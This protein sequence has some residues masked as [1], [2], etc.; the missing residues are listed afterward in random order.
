M[1]AADGL[2]GVMAK[3]HTP[4]P[5]T[6]GRSCD[7]TPA[8]IVPVPAGEGTG[9][10]VAHINRIPRMG[11]VRGDAD[12]NA[13]LIAAAPAMLDALERIAACAGGPVHNMAWRAIELAKEF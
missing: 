5:W 9:F 13:R 7:G 12:A 6:I 10:V 11:S 4:G 1:G 8:V 3:E 2:G